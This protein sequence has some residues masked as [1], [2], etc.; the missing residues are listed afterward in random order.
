MKGGLIGIISTASMTALLFTPVLRPG[1]RHVPHWRIDLVSYGFHEGKL[2]DTHDYTSD[3]AVAASASIVA[4]TIN[5]LA[6]D[7]QLVRNYGYAEAR[8]NFSLLLFDANS[9]KLLVKR[10]PWTAGLA[11]QLF[12][13]SQ[14]NFILDLHD[15]HDPGRKGGETLL[16]FSPTGE[17]L[18]E[19]D[20][21]PTSTNPQRHEWRALVSPT[22]KTVLVTLVDGDINR[23][24]V[25]D[26]NT[27]E[28]QFEGAQRSSDPAI[29]AISDEQMLGGMPSEQKSSPPVLGAEG[30][31]YIRPFR[32]AWRHLMDSSGNF[33]FLSE[34]RMAGLHRLG[35]MKGFLFTVI[36]TDG[37]RIMSYT[38][39][40]HN[41][42][43]SGGWPLVQ[44]SDGSFV[45]CI[46]VLDSEAWLWQVLDMGPEST[47]VYIWALPNPTPEFT[48]KVKSQFKTHLAF[49]PQGLWLAIADGRYL[50]AIAP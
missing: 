4:L 41:V 45:G 50:R 43:I 31:S 30:G 1:T 16:L 8:W 40:E 33:V 44:S 48:V 39:Q 11:S 19:L 47:E 25:L 32:G 3:T 37:T 10:G 46:F 24:K 5:N 28:E 9:G 20:L 21:A 17:Q 26:A 7:S 15:Y 6:P 12:A 49:S 27:L 34:D 13:T 42:A 36:T 22:G 29:L 14:G 38:V 18:R 23:Y 2:G 35:D